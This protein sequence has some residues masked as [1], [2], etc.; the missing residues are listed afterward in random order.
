MELIM[1]L[2]TITHLIVYFFVSELYNK[3]PYSVLIG[4]PE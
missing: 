4:F 1:F 3:S 2:F